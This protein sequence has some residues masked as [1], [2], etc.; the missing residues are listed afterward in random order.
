MCPSF[1]ETGSPSR[2]L[3]WSRLDETPSVISEGA[4]NAPGER[5][6]A[7]ISSHFIRFFMLLWRH[8]CKTPEE[9]QHEHKNKCNA[10]ELFHAPEHHPLFIHLDPPLSIEI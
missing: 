3:I 4:P 1:N 8:R 2:R 7:H 6:V 5:L 9:H 10:N